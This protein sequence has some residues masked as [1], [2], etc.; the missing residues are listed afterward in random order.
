MNDYNEIVFDKDRYDGDIN[1]M[2][3]VIAQ[4]LKILVDNGYEAR[5]Y[6]DDAGLGIYVIQF[7]YDNRIEDYGSARLMWVTSDEQDRICCEKLQAD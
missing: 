1:K 4:Q 7:N 3:D 5:F 6:A 2:F